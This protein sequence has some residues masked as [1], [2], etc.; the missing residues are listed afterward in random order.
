MVFVC[1]VSELKNAST[2]VNK[3]TDFCLFLL[4]YVLKVTTPLK[5]QSELRN[6][7]F[8]KVTAGS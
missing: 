6:L 4:N 5:L 3:C 7:I 1:L 8:P 2:M